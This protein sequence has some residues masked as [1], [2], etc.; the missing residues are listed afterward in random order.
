MIFYRPYYSNIRGSSRTDAGVHAIRNYF[1]IDIDSQSKPGIIHPRAIVSGLNEA[2]YKLDIIDYISITDAT[3][4]GLDFDVRKDAVGRTYMYR[5][6]NRN[7][8]NHH[9]KSSAL[10]GISGYMM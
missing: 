8:R 6:L 9:S 2:F 5:I 4:V 1:Q 10:L 7:T 3:I